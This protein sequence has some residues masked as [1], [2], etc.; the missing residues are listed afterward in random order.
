[1]SA[2]L[3]KPSLVNSAVFL[4]LFKMEG[5]EGIKPMFKNVVENIL[6]F[7]RAFWQHKI[8]LKDFLRAKM[9]QIEGKIVLILG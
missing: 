6:L 8:D 4:T 5:G 7:S 1:M 2:T 9:S 3:G